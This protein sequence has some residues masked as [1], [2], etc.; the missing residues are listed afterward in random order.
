MAINRGAWLVAAVC[1]AGSTAYAQAGQQGTPKEVY[2]RLE[3]SDGRDGGTATMTSNKKGVEISVQL[4]NLDP[5]T[6]AIHVHQFPKCDTPDF[7]T[8]GGHFNPAGKQHGIDNPQGHHAGDL[9]VNLV[10]GDDGMVKKT[11]ESKDL[12]L[13][14]K[15]PNSVFA[16]GGTSLMVH[17][18][19]D[20]MKSDP[21]GNAG[22]REACGIIAIQNTSTK[23]SKSGNVG[24]GEG[25]SNH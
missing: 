5:G 23:K 25:P 11:F 13:D 14:P 4:K 24:G 22:G 20:D 1:L 2:I 8:A 19:A 9:P 3:T 21:S 12:T 18:M 6:H 10:V 16:N 7:K 17:A 15:A